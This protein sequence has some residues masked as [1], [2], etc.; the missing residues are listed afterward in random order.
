MPYVSTES[1]LAVA[2][3]TRRLNA[4]RNGGFARLSVESPT[5]ASVWLGA[6]SVHRKTEPRD[7]AATRSSVLGLACRTIAAT[8]IYGVVEAPPEE[9]QERAKKA[10]VHLANA[11]NL[12]TVRDGASSS[13]FQSQN[14]LTQLAPVLPE[15]ACQNANN[16]RGHGTEEA[17]LL[18]LGGS[19]VLIVYP[20]YVPCGSVCDSDSRANNTRLGRRP[21]NRTIHIR[22]LTVQLAWPAGG[23]GAAD[24]RADTGRALDVVRAHADPQPSL[25]VRPSPGVP[26]GVPMG[27]VEKNW[28][29]FALL[30]ADATGRAEAGASSAARRPVAGSPR[31]FFH[32]WLERAG[33]ALVHEVCVCVH[34]LCMQRQ[35]P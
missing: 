13:L 30:P 4:L 26:L 25:A 5:R 21:F 24:Q 9:E 7:G 34:Y 29:P 28:A 11:S 1:Q 15:R 32:R 35:A 20:D 14:L 33:E 16:F 12:C 27:T 6:G 22:R 17:R 19:N 18:P 10:R 23:S 2:T 3:C 8:Q 31:V